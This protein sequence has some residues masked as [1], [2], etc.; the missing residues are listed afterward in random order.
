VREQRNADAVLYACW[1]HEQVNTTECHPMDYS[2]VAVFR[3]HGVVPRI[4]RQGG[5]FSIQGSPAVPME[6]QS[7]DSYSLCR[8]SIAHTYRNQLLSELSYYGVNSASLFPDLD[9]LSAFL[10]WAIETREYFRFS[11]EA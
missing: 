9:G 2:K 10:N 7:T 5:Q 3:P 6:A 8:I 4:T 11:S 1:F